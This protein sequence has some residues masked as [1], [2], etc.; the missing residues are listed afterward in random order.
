MGKVK[1]FNQNEI[2]K[3]FEI[4]Y[5]KRMQRKHTCTDIAISNNQKTDNHLR[6]CHFYGLTPEYIEL[7]KQDLTKVDF[8]TV[9]QNLLNMLVASR[10]YH[11]GLMLFYPFNEQRTS[12]DDFDINYQSLPLPLPC[13]KSINKEYD[14]YDIDEPEI[15]WRTK[16]I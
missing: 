15:Y 11:N 4:A 13:K 2:D 8:S 3:I 9:P 12:F 10:G 1:P 14:E 7:I 5:L 16:F 6:I